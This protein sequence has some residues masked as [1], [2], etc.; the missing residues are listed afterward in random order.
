MPAATTAKDL[1]LIAPGSRVIVRDLE[2]QVVE[3]ET[4][5]LGTKA[6]VRCVGRSELVRDQPAAFF[7]DLDEIKPEDPKRTNFRL[8]TSPNGIETRLILES[9]V[10]RDIASTA[11]MTTQAP[12]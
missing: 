7:S 12:V 9:L 4:Q 2:W 8:D 3:K 5:A 10:R 11:P 6:I 1:D